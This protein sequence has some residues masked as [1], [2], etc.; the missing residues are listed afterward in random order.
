MKQCL[1]TN[2]PSAFAVTQSLRVTVIG[3]GRMGS[4]M[5]RH[6]QEK[7]FPL[8]VYNRSRKKTEPFVAA[9]ARA[10]GTP[11]DAVT[12]TD[13]VSTSL[14]D[15]RSI[16]DMMTASD[17]ILAGLPRSAIHLSTSTISPKASARLAELH[18]EHG[19]YYVAT[20]VLGRPSAAQAGQLA[21]LIA[22]EPEIIERC[23]PVLEAFTNMIVD[24]GR[25]PADAA[26][27]KLTINFFLSGL[28]EAIGEAYVFA[29]K[30][31]LA[32]AT[33]RR[34]ITDQVLPNPAVREY[35]ERIE[36]RRYDEAG[37]TLITGYKDL[38][39]ILAEAGAVS[40]PLPIAALV[41]DH[42]LTALAGG[43]HDLDWCVSTEA[44]RL[45]AG[46]PSITRQP[47]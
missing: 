44:N 20:N 5:A 31:G 11:C 32:L 33:V 43:Q 41:R 4:G 23:R 36:T 28:I 16:L 2:N 42:I 24:V 47:T 10:A 46:L 14:V 3:L 13:I 39:L 1:F 29:E 15:D 27:M 22:G 26:R 45:A 38:E 19:S 18:R 21:A 34:L 17:G 6:I 40:A 9:G 35:A 37:A 12:A 7:G 25:N 8:I 30:H